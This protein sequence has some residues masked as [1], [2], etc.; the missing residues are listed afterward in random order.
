MKVGIFLEDIS[1]G[2]GGEVVSMRL[3]DAFCK[4]NVDACLITLKQTARRFSYQ[5]ELQEFKFSAKSLKK[6]KNRSEIVEVLVQNGYTHIIF[7]GGSPYTPFS[8]AKLL[9]EMKN[10]GMKLYVVI[11]NSPKNFSRRYYHKGE[12]IIEFL[13]KAAK[14]VFFSIPR[15]RMFFRAMRNKVDSF[16]TLSRGNH[17]ELQRYFKV[18]SSIIPN[19]CEI[20]SLCKSVSQKQKTL[21]Y[22]GRMDFEQKNIFYLIEAWK[23]VKDKNGWTFYMIGASVSDKKF[24]KRIAEAEIKLVSFGGNQGVMEFLA[25]NSILLLASVFEGFPT[26]ALEAAASANAIITTRYDGFSD[27]IARDKEN[28]FVIDDRLR[29]EKYT[30]AIQELITD[31]ELLLRMQKKSLE[32]YKEYSS[33]D[34]VGLWKKEF[35]SGK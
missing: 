13:C 31:N 3:C 30:K 19:Y 7:Q 28:A 29:T 18:P 8:N 22:V 25:S 26:V 17:A 10:A 9:S 21:A 34:V 23:N 14:T 4:N 6:R 24:L 15:S 2:A 35:E 1:Q 32:I 27:E 16:V 33:V 12:N 11:H 5:K 20:D